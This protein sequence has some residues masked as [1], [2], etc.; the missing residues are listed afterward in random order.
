[1]TGQICGKPVIG[2]REGNG[3]YCQ[4]QNHAHQRHDPGMQPLVTKQKQRQEQDHREILEA[5]GNPEEKD[6]PLILLFQISLEAQQLK[7]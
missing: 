7:H 3:G 6:K 5:E 4:G 1:M 2:F